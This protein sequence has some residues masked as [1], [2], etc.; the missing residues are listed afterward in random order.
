MKTD[1]DK[2]K[3]LIGQDKYNLLVQHGFMPL[4][5]DLIN[6]FL[7]HEEQIKRLNVQLSMLEK[8]NIVH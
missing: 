1:Q 7:K 6:V 4:E 5:M 8:P 2:A 3:R